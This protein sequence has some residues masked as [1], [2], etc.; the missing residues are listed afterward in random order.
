MLLVIVLRLEA[1]VCE[2]L[3]LSFEVLANVRVIGHHTILMASDTLDVGVSSLIV[4]R[5][6]VIFMIL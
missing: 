4:D 3:A 2:I 6:L 1:L 5:T